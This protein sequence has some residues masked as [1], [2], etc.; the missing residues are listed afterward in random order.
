ML[1]PLGENASMCDI[2]GKLDT[3]FGDISTN[4]MI[5]QEFFNSFQKENESVTEFGCRR[6]LESML[7][8]AIENG[9]LEKSSKSDILRHTFWTSLTSE[10]LKSQTH[11]KYDTIKDYDVLLRELRWVEKE[12]NINNNSTV[13]NSENRKIQQN[14]VLEHSQ[15]QGATSLAELE[16]K[17]D[18]KVNRLEKE[19][20]RKLTEV[21]QK[22]DK[23]QVPSISDSGSYFQKSNGEGRR[24]N[25]FNGRGNESYRR[26]QGQRFYQGSGGQQSQS[27]RFN[28]NK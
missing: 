12:V 19:M 4:G 13:S 6:R 5:M 3:L 28:T 22:L 15:G 24:G 7:Q 26:N 14:S 17:L 20:N 16:V 27:A 8:V 1:I 18:K 25:N 10:K 11:Y 21:I 9:Y 23:L 2:L